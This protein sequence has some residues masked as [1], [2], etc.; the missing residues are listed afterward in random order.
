MYSNFHTLKHDIH[1]ILK[2]KVVEE[3]IMH[4]IVD[5]NGTFTP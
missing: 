5:E 1:I 2:Y 3:E 4:E